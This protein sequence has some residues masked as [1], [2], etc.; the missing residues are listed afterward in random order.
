M[1]EIQE[2]PHNFWISALSLRCI[3]CLLILVSR[4]YMLKSRCDLPTLNVV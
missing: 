1:G 4:R 2:K 3:I